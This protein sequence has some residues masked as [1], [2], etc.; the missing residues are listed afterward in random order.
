MPQKARPEER[1][2][3]QALAELAGYEDVRTSE[4]LPTLSESKFMQRWGLPLMTGVEM[5]TEDYDPGAVDAAFAALPFVGGPLK[6]G[7]KLAKEGAKRVGS[8]YRRAVRPRV[9]PQKDE[10]LREERLQRQWGSVEPEESLGITERISNQ[11]LDMRQRLGLEPSSGSYQPGTYAQQVAEEAVPTQ[12]TSLFGDLAPAPQPVA[13]AARTSDQSIQH[14]VSETQGMIRGGVGGGDLTYN[15]ARAIFQ[16]IGE[17]GFDEFKEELLSM[18]QDARELAVDNFMAKYKLGA[19]ALSGQEAAAAYKQARFTSKMPDQVISTK[20]GSANLEVKTYRTSGTTS[21][22]SLDIEP[23]NLSRRWKGRAY[24]N[25]SIEKVTDSAGKTFDRVSDIHYYAHGS[26][27]GAK[28]RYSG[29]LMHELLK[30]VPKGTVIDE[31]MLTYDSLYSL[32]RTAMKT[33]SKIIFNNPKLAKRFSQS[34]APSEM[35]HISHLYN[36]AVKTGDDHVI[37]NAVDKVMVTLGD[38]IEQARSKGLVEGLPEFKKGTMGGGD[39]SYNAISVEKLGALV[40]GA[41][42]FKNREELMKFL[43]Y[44]PESTESQVFDREFSL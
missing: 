32:I 34:S 23:A 13:Q 21:H 29:L 35:T 28:L 39:I 6:A 18:P 3:L 14:I 33:N 8:A 2:I 15:Q 37:D 30:K 43:S 4:D 17:Q 24:I 5:E 1:T 41:F 16:D 38:M 22:I 31:S 40:A 44:D 19:G 36:E 42:G 11:L 9:F 10:L 7:F 25:F 26:E 20:R 27:I 12:Q